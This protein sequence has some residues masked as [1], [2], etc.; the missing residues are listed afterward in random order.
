MKQKQNI[1][2]QPPI[3][4]TY[5][6]LYVHIRFIVVGG[7]RATIGILGTLGTDTGVF[8]GS[9]SRDWHGL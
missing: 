3:V 9:G 7:T 8:L 2:T 4:N 6:K 1:N 5:Y